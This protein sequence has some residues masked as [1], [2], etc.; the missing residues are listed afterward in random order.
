MAGQLSSVMT[1]AGAGLLPNPGAAVGPALIVGPAMTQA[2]NNYTALPVVQRYQAIVQAADPA[3]VT[4]L[5]DL[6]STDF[7][8]LTD[9][10]PAGSTVASMYPAQ[11]WEDT[12]TYVTTNQ[13]L[14]VGSV[15]ESIQQSLDRLPTDPVYWDKILDS[16]AYFSDVVMLAAD[17]IA[18][19]GDLGK[20]CQAFTVAKTY[21]A[22]T[23]DTLL[24]I[25][26]SDIL[27]QTFNPATGGMD[28]LTTG[29]MNQVSSDLGLLA[30]DL[31]ALGNM[32]YLGNLP[33]LGLPGELVA[34]LGRVSGSEIPE[35]SELMAA[36]GISVFRIRE[37]SQG[38]NLLTSQE[39]KTLYRVMLAINGDLLAQIQAI[40][41]MRTVNITNMTQMLDPRWYLPRSYLSLL[42]PTPQSLAPIYFQ[43]G[44]GWSVN[45]SLRDTLANPVISFYSGP[46]N[47]NSLDELSRIIPPDQALAVKAWVRALQ[48]IKNVAETTLP[49]LAR[50]MSQIETNQGLNLIQNLT[51]PVP[52]AV[53]NSWINN[54]G[55][56]TGEADTILLTDIVGVASGQTYAPAFDTMIQAL[57]Q[58]DQQ[59]SLDTLLGTSGVY[60]VMENCQAGVYTQTVMG[61]F[62]VV[63]PPGLPG[64]GTYGDFATAQLA[65][66]DAFINGLTPAA[67]SIISALVSANPVLVDQANTAQ[68]QMA[69]QLQRESNNIQLSQ[70]SIN[71]FEPDSVSA[72]ISFTANL[73]EYGLD[74]APGG[75]NDV[76][77]AMANTASL[78]GQALLASLREGRNIQALQRAGIEVDTQLPG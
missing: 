77:E 4:G 56:G 19:D 72:A 38:V 16:T 17:R 14:Y 64:A 44:N 32:I 52:V 59:G 1:I 39:E 62:R 3:Y 47:T 31:E 50:A 49:A 58:L 73:H 70:M 68:D 29:S 18:G 22:Q 40:F 21:A 20:F 5:R 53:D 8:A 54:V 30:R 61:L 24:A 33:D 67:Q 37:L 25:S 28:S 66:N 26:S 23:N 41:G 34:Q 9:H 78:S 76:L 13:V 46:N 11:A 27:A 42:C 63:I 43:D 55:S 12:V 10:Q 69:Q 6:G 45:Q 15:Y 36:A 65:I 35:F 60:T 51:D 57:E 71:E 7:P 2:R 48:Q 74:V 75:A